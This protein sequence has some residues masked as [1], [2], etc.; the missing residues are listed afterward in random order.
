VIVGGRWSGLSRAALYSRSYG[1]AYFSAGLP[2]V[3]AIGLIWGD[4]EYGDFTGIMLLAHVFSLIVVL[5]AAIPVNFVALRFLPLRSWRR[6]S[7]RSWVAAVMAVPLV[8][9]GLAIWGES[10]GEPPA[11]LVRMAG[12][13][14]PFLQLVGLLIGFSNLSLAIAWVLPPWARKRV[15]D[16]RLAG[17]ESPAGG[18][19]EV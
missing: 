18:E 17:L 11:I 8:W 3:L 1:W 19:A 2:V 5:P 13:G 12:A 7:W 9:G 15:R 14:A 6:S 16:R 10:V 4:S